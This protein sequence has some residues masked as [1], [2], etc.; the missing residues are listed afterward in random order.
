M[1]TASKPKPPK[2]P[3][4]K[5]DPYRYGWRYVRVV[6]ADGSETFDRV[7]LTLEDVL[8]PEEEDFIADSNAHNGD[9]H[10]LTNVFEVQLAKDP[11]AVVLWKCRVDWNLP[12]VRP[13]GSDIAVFLGVKRSRDWSTFSVAKERARP[14]LVVEV[15]NPNTRQNDLGPKVDYYHRAGVP[16]YLIADVPERTPE[17]RITLIG[18]RHA[19]RGYV[20]VAPDE[21]G[22]IDLE[23]VRLCVGV[24]RHHRGAYHRL[25]CYDPTTGQEIAD[26]TTLVQALERVQA[27]G[28]VREAEARA[29]AE[30]K[31][32]A[33]AEQ[34]IRELEAEPKRSRGRRS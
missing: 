8:F 7:P 16:L 10:Y 9:V 33:A 23:P 2:P 34:R 32:R 6:A 21:K 3:K 1:S 5:P 26:Y 30:A 12:G 24:T 19:P 4:P 29:Q 18:Y 17:R 13:L 14:A 27:A 20:R 25:A 28:R 15:T 31:A 22:L 11:T